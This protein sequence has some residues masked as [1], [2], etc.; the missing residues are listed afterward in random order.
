ME[1]KMGKGLKKAI[2]PVI[3]CIILSGL[4]A[5]LLA[6]SGPVRSYLSLDLSYLMG[7]IITFLVLRLGSNLSNV[8]MPNLAGKLLAYSL[9]G[10][11]FAV[12]L[13]M[14]LSWLGQQP[15]VQRTALSA[16]STL[17]GYA[18]LWIAGITVCGLAGI[19]DE[20]ERFQRASPVTRAV[21]LLMV[22]FA[23]FGALSSFAEVWEFALSVGLV[24]MAG[25]IASAISS[26]ARYGEKS[27]NRYVA[28]A[29]QLI[30]ESSVW[31]FILGAILFSYIA[32]VRPLIADSFS[33]A[34][35]VEWGVVC[36]V[37]LWVY[38]W[39]RVSIR[40]TYSAPLKISEVEKHSQQLEEMVDAQLDYLGTI[41]E[42][43]VEKGHRPRLL[44]SLIVMLLENGWDRDRI[45]NALVPLIDYEEA[46]VPWYAFI[47]N[48]KRIQSR[49]E[50]ERKKVLTDVISEVIQQSG[51]APRNMEVKV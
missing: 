11:S 44:V 38:R 41:Q 46:E 21:G 24:M 25:F 31:M 51:N 22:G 40:D 12:L 33:Y 49:G 37:A 14:C 10:A 8:L 16:V 36:L 19:L 1:V 47:W 29:S 45:C 7:P 17:S 27:S 2:T 30:A 18:I 20:E 5:F 48:H 26:L 43:F 32:L 35:L 39:A 13:V 15:E 3:V 6:P 42:A 23:M 28:S 50:N 9:S 34:T 4:T